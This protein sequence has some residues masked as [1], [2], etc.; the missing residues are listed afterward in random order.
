MIGLANKAFSLASGEYRLLLGQADTLAPFALFEI[1]KA[2]NE[3]PQTD[4]IYSD[5]DMID[6]FR[7]GSFSAPL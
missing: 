7:P 5:E 1:V 6:L 2:I 3:D 4:F